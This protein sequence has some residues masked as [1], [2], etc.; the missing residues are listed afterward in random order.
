MSNQVHWDVKCLARY[1]GMRNVWPG[2][3]DEEYLAIYTGMRNVWP[4]TLG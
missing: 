2:I 3:L 1:T 4:G